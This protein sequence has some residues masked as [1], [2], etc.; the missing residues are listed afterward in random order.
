MQLSVEK[1][2]AISVNRGA[3]LDS[4]DVPLNSREILKMHF[5]NIREMRSEDQRLKAIE[6]LVK[7]AKV[8]EES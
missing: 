4:I 3:N 1:Y 6:L 5:Y 8:Y 7:L 2:Q